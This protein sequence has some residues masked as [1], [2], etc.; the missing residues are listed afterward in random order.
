MNED[1]PPLQESYGDQLQILEVNIQNPD[2]LVIYEAYLRDFNVPND[3]RGVPAMVVGETYLVGGQ[4]I[5]EAF[6]AIVETGVLNA[7][8]DWPALPGLDAYIEKYG[9]EANQLTLGERFGQDPVGNSISTV[10]LV[11]MI[12]SAFLAW[13]AYTNANINLKSWPDWFTPALAVIGVGIS[14]YLSYIEITHTDAVCGPIGDCNAVQSSSYAYFLGII[15]IA[16]LG[17]LSYLAIGVAWV[18]R[19]FGET[20]SK[21]TIT[22]TIWWFALIGTLF[23]IYLTFLEPFV[24]GAT[25]AWCIASAITMTLILWTTTPEIHSIR[26]QS[27]RRPGYR[28]FRTRGAR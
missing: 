11:G 21:K 4:E 7:G 15:P 25:C 9:F 3:R 12:I 1:L 8:L 23:S 20:E 28:K 22:M 27:S 16:V 2:G 13:Y 18:V 24:I 19:K 6:P 10:I 5:P 14:I 26:H 17:L